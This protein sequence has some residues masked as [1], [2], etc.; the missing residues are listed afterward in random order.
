[1]IA[2]SSDDE[3]MMG[4]TMVKD[5]TFRIFIKGKMLTDSHLFMISESCMGYSQC[6]ATFVLWVLNLNLLGLPFGK[7]CIINQPNHS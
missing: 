6:T 3:L 7:C 4:L 5:D 1:M 2:F